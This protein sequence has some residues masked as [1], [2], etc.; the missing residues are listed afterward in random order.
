MRDFARVAQL[1]AE[2]AFRLLLA[3]H[4]EEENSL[5][6]RFETETAKRLNEVSANI[7]MRSMPLRGRKPGWN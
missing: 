2:E 1:S 7:G 3:K 4:K 6:L 5:W